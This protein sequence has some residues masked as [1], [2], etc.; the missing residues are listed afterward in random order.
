MSQHL[1]PTAE[2]TAA[3]PPSLS[4]ARRVLAYP[5]VWALLGSLAIFLTS[6]LYGAARPHAAATQLLGALASAVLAIVV[7]L[8]VLRGLARRDTPELPL[9]QGA[10]LAPLGLGLG[11]GAG[12][13]V[14]STLLVAALGGYSFTRGS[15]AT[16][17]V[18]LEALAMALTAAVGEELVFRG[19]VFRAVE[20]LAGERRPLGAVLAVTV[21]SLFFGLAHIANPSATVWSALAIA[22]EAGVLLGVVFLW[23]RTLWVVIGLHL[24]WN[25]VERLLGFAVSGL[26]APGLLEA[27]PHGPT[28]LSGGDFGLEASV[29]PVVLSLAV[30]AL[31]LRLRRPAPQ[32]PAL[33]PP[34]R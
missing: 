14:L 18:L 28:W 17:V 11:I 25:F 20:E 23:R 29:V 26:Q 32:P 16:G 12:F 9:G 2:D 27:S 15:A 19:L 21:T 33:Q 13:I 31:A 5:V 7:Y 30:V 10:V 6:A 3:P 34:V 8:A 24:A 4:W 1:Q 22:V